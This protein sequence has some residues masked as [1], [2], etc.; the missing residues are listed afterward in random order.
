M[1]RSSHG[2]SKGTNLIAF[3]GG[4]TSWVGEGRVVHVVYLDFSQAF[5]TVSHDVLI[6]KLGKYILDETGTREVKQ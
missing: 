2:L 3:Y 6:S 5:D 1:I 4:M